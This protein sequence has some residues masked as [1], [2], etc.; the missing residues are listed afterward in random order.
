MTA[1]PTPEVATVGKAEFAAYIGVSPG[2]VS[3]YIAEGKISGD[4]LVGPGR[5]SRIR[6]E[7]AVAQLRERLDPGQM[8]GNGK[9]TR[10]GEAAP[11]VISRAS[12]VHLEAAIRA[13]FDRAR[14][15][16]LRLLRANLSSG[17]Q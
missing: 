9:T 3:Q 15:D 14:D 10:L 11:V 1:Q 7:I 4:A 5:A 13:R 12:A 2:R 17:G 6:V 16:V 8:T